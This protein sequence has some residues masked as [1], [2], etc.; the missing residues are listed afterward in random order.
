MTLTLREVCTGSQS[1]ELVVIDD[2][3]PPLAAT[4]TSTS[5]RTATTSAGITA[6]A[7]TT[8]TA[9]TA[10]SALDEFIVVFASL[11]AEQVVVRG[12]GLGVDHVTSNS[13]LNR[14]GKLL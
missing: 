8:T 14:L 2:E 3:F 9:S 5:L 6:T 10:T 12:L 13:G 4:P 1:W 11:E 7:S